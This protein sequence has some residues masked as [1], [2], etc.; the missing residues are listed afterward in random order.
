MTRV[1]E[2]AAS[3]AALPSIPPLEADTASGDV[4]IGLAKLSERSHQTALAID[5]MRGTLALIQ[6][7]ITELV[8]ARVESNSTDNQLEAQVQRLD[9]DGQE[10]RTALGALQRWRAGVRG[11]TAVLVALAGIASAVGSWALEYWHR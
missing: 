9:K 6:R 7:G 5:Q 8:C 3:A 11:S 1:A 4:R 10:L 2:D